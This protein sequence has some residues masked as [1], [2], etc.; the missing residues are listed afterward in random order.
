MYCLYICHGLKKKTNCMLL[1][2]WIS[3][4]GDT[5]SLSFSLGCHHH[6]TIKIIKK[7]AKME[8]KIRISTSKQI[9]RTRGDRQ[10]SWRSRKTKKEK[11][12][13][14][15]NM[16]DTGQQIQH[17]LLQLVCVPCLLNSEKRPR[18]VM[19]GPVKM[20]VFLPEMFWQSCL[21]TRLWSWGL[22]FKV[23][24]PSVPWPSFRC[25][26]ICAVDGKR[27]RHTHTNKYRT[28]FI[29]VLS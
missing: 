26:E 20:M 13:C 5:V 14:L 15:D 24:R 29:S 27:A 3:F 9:T 1:C 16:A 28:R 23:A 11:V 7:N 2:C 17:L 12:L 18:L 4:E 10:E 21:A 6:T 8:W 22:F 25:T 19:D